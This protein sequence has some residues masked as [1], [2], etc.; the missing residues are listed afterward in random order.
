MRSGLLYG[1]AGQL[2]GL[3][4]RI[5]NELGYPCEKIATGGLASKIVPYCR[6]KI[7]SDDNRVLNGMWYL[8]LKNNPKSD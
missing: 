3:I 2:D 4:D 7:I 6:H 5:E 8:Y 1:T